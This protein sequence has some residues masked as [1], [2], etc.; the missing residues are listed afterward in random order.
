MTK[1]LLLLAL[2]ILSTFNVFS[3]IE[4]REMI[5]SV[6]GNYSQ[7]TIESGVTN[8]LN[9]N[10]GKYLNI[11]ASVGYFIT[12]RLITGIGFDYNWGKEDRLN[13]LMINRY[14]QSEIT[15]IKSKVFL[16]NLYI[17]YYYPITNKLYVN[18][19]IKFSYGKIK[20]EYDSFWAGRVSYPSG[21]LIDLTDEYSSSYAM[22]TDGSSKVDYLGI[23]VLPELSY[24]ISSRFSLYIGLGGV[25]Y[26]FLDWKTDN[27]S[28]SINFNPTCWKT[29]IKIKI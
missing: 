14:Y 24:F 3:Q 25:S 27:S 8:N 17:G 23:D 12:D 22:S 29:G 16:P 19:N 15:N 7:S 6:D 13:N 20:S 10:Q 26:S 2:A 5:I 18:L 1:K 11:G 28:W 9:S 4:K 21:T